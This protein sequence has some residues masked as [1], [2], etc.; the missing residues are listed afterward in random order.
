VVF[1]SSVERSNG[2]SAV[3]PAGDTTIV[4]NPEPVILETSQTALTTDVNGL[5]SFL[6]SDA[7]FGGALQIVGNATAGLTQVP[8]SIQ[9][10][11]P[12]SQ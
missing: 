2:S 3:T 1:Q 11:P 5:V 4:H 6:P 10:L 12:L 8:F 9:L 7:G